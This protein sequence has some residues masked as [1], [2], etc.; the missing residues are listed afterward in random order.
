M[1]IDAH[2]HD[3][4]PSIVANVTKKK[5]MAELLCLETKLARNRL[6]IANLQKRMEVCNIPYCVIPFLFF[7]D[8]L[9]ISDMDNAS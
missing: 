5:D 7:V 4:S 2:V 9:S 6:G 1:I 8:K 3:F